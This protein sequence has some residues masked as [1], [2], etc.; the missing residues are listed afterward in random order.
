VLN[1]FMLEITLIHC[2]LPEDRLLNCC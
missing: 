1:L 2:N